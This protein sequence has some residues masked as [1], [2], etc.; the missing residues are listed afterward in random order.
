[1]SK[2]SNTLKAELTKMYIASSTLTVSS[3]YVSQSDTP[4]GMFT[5]KLKISPSDTIVVVNVDR[6]KSLAP[7]II[8]AK[9]VL[10]LL[11]DFSGYDD[12]DANLDLS[13]LR[14]FP[15]KSIQFEGDNHEGCYWDVVNFDKAVAEDLGQSILT[16]ILQEV[17]ETELY[18]LI[19]A[20]CDLMI[21]ED[22]TMPF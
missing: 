11:I 6:Y 19:K 9:P 16:T 8:N 21:I 4:A 20:A 10:N 14:L 22:K 1:M 3:S 17:N 12:D 15:N 5:T 7:E 2:L 13:S 18:D